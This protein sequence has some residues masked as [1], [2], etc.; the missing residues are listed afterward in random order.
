VAQ[1]ANKSQPIGYDFNGRPTCQQLIGPY[2]QIDAIF[3]LKASSVE[4]ENSVH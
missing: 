4:I 1:T 3:E 2:P